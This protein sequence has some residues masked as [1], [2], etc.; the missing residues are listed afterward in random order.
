MQILT[1]R[2]NVQDHDVQEMKT[3]LE[4]HQN[5]FDNIAQILMNAD[6]KSGQHDQQLKKA[7]FSVEDGV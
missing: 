3:S 4:R 2:M 1:Q 6:Q 5:Y 7:G